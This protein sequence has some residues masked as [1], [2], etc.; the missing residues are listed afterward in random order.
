V[1]NGKSAGAARPSLNVIGGVILIV[2]TLWVARSVLIPVALAILLT[3]ILTPL[4]LALQRRG[5]PKTVAIL[6]VTL[7]LLL[8]IIGGLIVLTRELHDLAGELPAHKET[9][10]H[11]L[12]DLQGEG[13]GVFENLMRM[14]EEITADISPHK[15]E[16][17][18]VN[19]RVVESKTTG[20]SLLP[21]LAMPLLSFLGSVGLVVAL[22]VSM[23][24]KRAD[25]RNRLLRLFGHGSLTSSTRAMDEG[26]QR[27]S[28]YLVVQVMINTGFGTLFALGLAILG[29]PYAL[30]WGFLAGVLRF[31]PFIGTWLGGIFPVLISVAV[32]AGWIQPLLVVALL[33]VLGLVA[34]NVIEPMLVSRSTG[35][36]PIALVVAAAFWA[37]LWGPIGLV[38]STPMTVCLV[39]MGRYVPQLQFLD[40]L[41]GTGPALDPRYGYYQ[42]LLAHDETEAEELVEEYLKEHGLESLCDEVLVPVLIRTREDLERGD[43]GR[44]EVDYI[45]QATRDVLDAQSLPGWPEEEKPEPARVKVMGWPAR[46][47][48]DELAL[49]LFQLVMGPGCEVELLSTRMVTTEM[50][51]WVKQEQSPVLLLASIP[52]G[53]A[54]KVR[55]L[56]KHLRR[57]FPQLRIFVGCWGLSDEQGKRVAQLTAAG[58]TQVATRLGQSREQLAPLLP[59]LPHLQEEAAA[60]HATAA[61]AEHG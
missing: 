35:V 29:V 48:V 19:V 24:F 8:T 47:A 7:L 49:H 2:A 61:S 51:E 10:A 6:G 58:A 41:L 22:T 34:N 55:Y 59:V 44:E 56:C 5:V 43:L 15:N 52:A 17:G 53:G 54:T 31:I 26:A 33:V 21:L 27:V 28:S 23:L 46:D 38:L 11:K 20:L 39:V 18:V 16:D 25:L 40:I 37:W 14:F 50:V 42:R 13:P 1:A 60:A 45:L 3:F 32:A 57:Q 12:K 36:S 30:L 4:V 9:I